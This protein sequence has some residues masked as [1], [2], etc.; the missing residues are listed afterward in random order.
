M[1]EYTEKLPEKLY[2]VT[3][4]RARAGKG[5]R[6]VSTKHAEW[7][8]AT[9]GEN[10]VAWAIRIGKGICKLSELF[11]DEKS[12]RDELEDILGKEWAL[13]KA[14]HQS[15]MERLYKSMNSKISRA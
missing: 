12:A 1:I 11:C 4:E 14:R 8:F 15:V 13:E 2:L 6:E 7:L 10:R 3:R 9:V 5:I